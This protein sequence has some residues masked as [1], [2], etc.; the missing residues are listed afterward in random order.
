MIRLVLRLY[1]R[2]MRQEA[3]VN[4]NLGHFRS[5]ITSERCVISTLAWIHLDT[6]VTI[7]C[8]LILT[9]CGDDG[10]HTRPTIAKRV[11]RAN[12]GRSCLLRSGRSPK[13]G[14]CLAGTNL[15]SSVYLQFCINKLI[16]LAESRET[17]FLRR[18][19]PIRTSLRISVQKEQGLA[20]AELRQFGS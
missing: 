7:E 19:G 6:V 1:R 2:Q 18:A 17:F 10:K 4:S 11:R 9:L 15:T 20:S 16:N 12:I 8:R 13:Q 3:L 14:I 5:H